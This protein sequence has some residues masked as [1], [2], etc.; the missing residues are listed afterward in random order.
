M[1][2][3]ALS[4][5]VE[6]IVAYPPLSEMSDLQRREFHKALLDASL[7]RSGRQVAGG[8][9]E[10]RAEPARPEDR[11]QRLI[12]GYG[13]RLPS[14]LHLGLHPTPAPSPAGQR[15]GLFPNLASSLVARHRQSRSRATPELV[16]LQRFVKKGWATG[17]EPATAWTTPGASIRGRARRAGRP[18]EAR[19]SGSSPAKV[20]GR[21]RAAEVGVR[22]Q[23][24][25]G[26]RVGQRGNATRMRPG[27]SS[28]A[29]NL[30]ST[31]R[32]VMNRLAPNSGRL[33]GFL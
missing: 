18:R 6:K 12:G 15:C 10:G 2:N 26:E 30:A 27:A 4:R 29:Q 24:V 11:R 9:P 16:V 21:R 5:R 28:E 1:A 14:P 19:R 8:D 33:Q 3:T 13:A 23:M 17:L 25:L 31:R 20:R 32:G 22:G 7:R